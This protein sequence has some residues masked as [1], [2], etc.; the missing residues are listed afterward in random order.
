MK[1][2]LFMKENEKDRESL[3]K[4][5]VKSLEEVAGLYN[6]ALLMLPVDSMAESLAYKLD[7]YKCKMK[8]EGHMYVK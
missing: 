4:T 1:P 8:K 5:I 2:Q 6:S 3:I 7:F